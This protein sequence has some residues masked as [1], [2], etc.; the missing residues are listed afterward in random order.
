[1]PDHMYPRQCYKMLKTL[2]DI[3]QMGN[4]SKITNFI[5][6]DLAMCGFHKVLEI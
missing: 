2:D 6:M 3:G 1:M 4:K 5:L